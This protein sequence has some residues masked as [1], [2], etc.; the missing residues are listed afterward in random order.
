MDNG[1]QFTSQEFQQFVQTNKIRHLTSNPLFPQGNG[2]AERTVQTVKHLMRSATDPYA[3]LLAYRTTPLEH[4][5][6]PAQLLFGR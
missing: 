4:G 1:R 2:M 5:Y 3:A 6:S